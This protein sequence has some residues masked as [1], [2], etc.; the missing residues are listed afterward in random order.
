MNKEALISIMSDI[1]TSSNRLQLNQ[2]KFEEYI[3]VVKT[4]N[5]KITHSI[6]KLVSILSP[7]K[8]CIIIPFVKP[9]KFTIK[10][11]DTPALRISLV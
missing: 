4:E 5:R 7:K 8:E 11:K 9:S 3:S 10:S 6:N 2:S 1:D